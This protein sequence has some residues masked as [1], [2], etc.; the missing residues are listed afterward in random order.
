VVNGWEHYSPYATASV[1]YSIQQNPNGTWGQPTLITEGPLRYDT[2]YASGGYYITAA[3]LNK[4][5]QALL[6]TSYP[7]VTYDAL[8]YNTNS[9]TL[10]DLETL[11][12]VVNS[13]YAN[14][15]P[16]AIDDLGRIL[17]RE[18]P[19]DGGTVDTLL[20]TPDG[21]ST[22]PLSTPEPGALAVWV[23]ISAC[24]VARFVSRRSSYHRMLPI[25]QSRITGR[26]NS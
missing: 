6:A 11:S 3:G 8:V 10:T 9:H 26:N 17:V 5:G 7:N 22:N 25:I 4:E 1:A 24:L 21:V 20:F 18:G 2:D 12:A 14:F 23:V 19:G 15:V 13:N 16:I